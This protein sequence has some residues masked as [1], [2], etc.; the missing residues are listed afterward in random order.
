M[1]QELVAQPQRQRTPVRL[2]PAWRT[3]D[4]RLEQPRELDERLFVKPD[5]I[6]LA[7]ADTGG[8]QAVLDRV[9][10]KLGIVLDS[11]EALLL[12]GGDNPRRRVTRC[13]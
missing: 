1:D 2:N 13:A 12:R 9:C 6:E 3:R 7:G 4:V 10:R 11:C 5:E 8:A